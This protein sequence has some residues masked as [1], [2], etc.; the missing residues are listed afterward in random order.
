MQKRQEDE[1][2]KHQDDERQKLIQLQ[3]KADE[4]RLKEEARR[5]Q[6][7][8]MHMQRQTD[9]EFRQLQLKEQE[10]L[11][12]DQQRRLS[13]SASPVTSNEKP[14]TLPVIP[15]A[16][17]YDEPPVAVLPPA[18]P[19]ALPPPYTSVVYIGQKPTIPSRDLKPTSI[20]MT[21]VL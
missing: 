5:R 1:R 9:E 16:P 10:Q 18:T 17:L 12:L 20:T 15:S 21:Y 14:A 2:Q 4:M 8:E 19:N 11:E 13:D 6:E 3:Q 7:M